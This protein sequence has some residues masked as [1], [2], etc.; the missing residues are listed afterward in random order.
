MTISDRTP[1]MMRGLVIR[2]YWDGAEQPAV[3]V[4][5]GDFFCMPHGQMAPFEN[6]WFD[7]AEGRSFNCR[8]P[9]PF[10]TGF[11]CTVTN[12]SPLPLRLFFYEAN[13]TLG[14]VHD[15][16]TGYF[17]AHWRREK[18]TTQGKDFEILPHVRGRGRFL[19]CNIGVIADQT[20]YGRRWWGEGE[21]K[22]YLDGDGEFPTLCGT[23]TED[24]VGTAWG[25]GRF[26]RQWHGSPLVD[27]DQMKYGF[28]RLH[29]P[30]PVYFHQEIR[31]VMQQ[32]GSG[33]LKQL[34][35]MMETTGQATLYTTNRGVL[36]LEQLREV[37]GRGIYFEREDDWCATAYFCLDKPFAEGEPLAPYE[38]RVRD[39]DEDAK[40]REQ[41]D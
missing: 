10:R 12:E 24:Y 32:L 8:I 4:P 7:S 3:E 18:P 36:S 41:F 39:L 13:F 40:A 31:V 14:D 9:M 21:V 16:D 35:E 29:G 15:E 5:L 2:F 23:G 1:E 33:S 38:E 27:R 28:Y 20:R 37:Q 6:A 17:H 30:D 19:G 26:D 11:R 34:I 25:Q 22:I